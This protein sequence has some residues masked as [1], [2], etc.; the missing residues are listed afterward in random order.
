[1]TNIRYSIIESPHRWSILAGITAVVTL[2]GTMAIIIYDWSHVFAR[3]FFYAGLGI[4]L[5]FLIMA[6][7]EWKDRV[8]EERDRDERMRSHRPQ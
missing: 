1:V 4:T 5:V 7:L 6:L 8:Q 3:V 2:V